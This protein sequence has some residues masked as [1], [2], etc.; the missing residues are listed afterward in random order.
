MCWWRVD[1]AGWEGS[2]SQDRVRWEEPQTVKPGGCPGA[3]IQL[4]PL[5]VLWA[6]ACR[7]SGEPSPLR[8]AFCRRALWFRGV[9][10]DP[11]SR[12]RVQE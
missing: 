1:G 11:A 7:P 3:L 9:L 6:P 5:P 2:G 8:R 10:G 12:T 4:R